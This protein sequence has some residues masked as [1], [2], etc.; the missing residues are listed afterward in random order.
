MGFF[1]GFREWAYLAPTCHINDISH[2][3]ERHRAVDEVSRVISGS[4]LGQSSMVTEE[5]ERERALRIAGRKMVVIVAGLQIC[6]CHGRR[7]KAETASYH[8][9]CTRMIQ[10]KGNIFHLHTETKACSHM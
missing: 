3:G 9:R 8:E 6:G 5:R 7:A 2:L 10:G 1:C 4:P